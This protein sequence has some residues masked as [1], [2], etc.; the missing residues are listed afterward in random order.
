VAVPLLIAGTLAL[1]V[2]CGVAVA[3]GHAAKRRARV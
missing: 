2:G 3:R 1:A